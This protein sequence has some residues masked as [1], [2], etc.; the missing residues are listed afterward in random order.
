MARHLVRKRLEAQAQG[1]AVAAPASPS[2]VPI[3][4]AAAAGVSS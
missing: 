4:P 3:M 2:V 1:K